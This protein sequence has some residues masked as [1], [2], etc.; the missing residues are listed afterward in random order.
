M[1]MPTRA[2]FSVVKFLVTNCCIV[3]VLW[4]PILWVGQY[5]ELPR[6][7]LNKMNDVVV[8]S[9]VNANNSL[10]KNSKFLLPI[11]LRRR[12]I[13]FLESYLKIQFPYLHKEMAI[14]RGI[15]GG[16]GDV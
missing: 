6:P 7:V 2:V 10:T 8:R 9:R 12:K 11:Y 5:R 16:G 1:L 13:V 3:S 14:K 4:E 15:K